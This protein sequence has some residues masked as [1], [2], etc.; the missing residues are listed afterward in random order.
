M[1]VGAMDTAHSA[2]Y[3]ESVWKELQHALAWH[4]STDNFP[5]ALLSGLFT[6]A[7]QI[8]WGS[9]GLGCRVGLIA[10]ARETSCCSAMA[11]ES[12]MMMFSWMW[13]SL[14]MALG[15]S[16]GAEFHGWRWLSQT[17]SLML[18]T[19]DESERVMLS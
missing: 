12:Q 4:T 17:A 16:D 9:N 18:Q 13:S 2:G 10:D 8:P 7:F 19:S 14:W 1:L 5:I 6:A 15:I 3:Y 11:L